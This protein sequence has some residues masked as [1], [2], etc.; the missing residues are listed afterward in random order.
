MAGDDQ[1]HNPVFVLGSRAEFEETRRLELKEVR[2]HDPV[3]A[4]ANASDEYTVSFLNSEG[5]TIFWG[6]RDSDRTVVGVPLSSQDCDRLRR[7]IND[8]LHAIQPSIDPTRYRVELHPLAGGA[9]KPQ[10]LY[11][12]ELTVPQ[13]AQSEPFYTGGGDAF[14]RVD[15]VTKKLKGPQ[16]TDWIRQRNHPTA[17]VKSGPTDPCVAVLVTRIRRIFSAHE[18]EPAHLARF[19][20]TCHAPFTIALTDYQDDGAFLAW[21]SEEKID[22]IA[23]TFLIRREWID[24]EDARIHEEF[25]FDKRPEKFFET[26]SQHVDSLIWDEVHDSPEAYFIRWG[27]AVRLVSTHDSDILFVLRV[28]LARFSNERTIWKYIA[29]TSCYPWNYARTNIELRAWARLLFVNK[30]IGCHGCE[31]PYDVAESME[32]NSIFLHEVI[33]KKLRRT[34]DDWH[35]EDHALYPDESRVAKNVDTLP[36]VL[37]FLQHHNLP[38]EKTNLGPR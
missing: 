31:V 1:P 10:N 19:F 27:S 26:V 7:A 18:L 25:H 33:E 14:V 30:G 6:I 38:F 32:S 9:T 15:G 29:D 17:S 11:V 34:K 35:P 36:D 2:G 28:P 5:G 21:L 4:I 23:R 16:L 12:V 37:A 20:K 8:K 22:W 3:G 13:V 24:G